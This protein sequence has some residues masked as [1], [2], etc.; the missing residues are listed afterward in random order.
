MSTN[1]SATGGI[2]V[3]DSTLYGMTALENAFHDVIAGIAELSPKLVRPARQ[4]EPAKQPKPGTDWC[5]FEIVRVSSDINAHVQHVSTK[6]GYD[7]VIDHDV[8][9]LAVAFYGP[10]SDAVCGR[11]R[12]GLFVWQNREALRRVG[13]VV[14]LVGN[15]ISMPELDSEVWVSRT[16]LDVRFVVEVK[17]RYAVLNLL[18]STGDIKSDDGAKV[19]FDTE[20]V[21]PNG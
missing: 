19:S 13:I 21:K 4:I 10:N 8:Y 5:A 17:G 18:R 12:R 15:P 20:E 2:L 14:Q 6:D 9:S 11:F 7:V 1:T 16:D 3:E